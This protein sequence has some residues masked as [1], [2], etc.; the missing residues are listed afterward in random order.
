MGFIDVEV[1]RYD[2]SALRCGCGKTAEHLA[3]D[4]LRLAAAQSREEAQ[5]LRIEDHALIQSFPQEP[6]VPVTSVLMAALAGDLSDG[7]RIQCLDLLI[8]LVDTDDDESAD[9]CQQI[10]RQGLWGL[11]RDMWSGASRA[12]VGYAYEILQVIETEEDRLRAFRD[13]GQL[14]LPDDLAD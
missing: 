1:S 14:N 6:A 9:M 11:Y 4:L 13:S 10:A 12:L 3:D 8:R 2:W 5:A 7:A